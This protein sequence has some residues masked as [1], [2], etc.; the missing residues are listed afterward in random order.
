M[1]TVMNLA[2]LI[3]ANY[4][5]MKADPELGKGAVALEESSNACLELT[6]FFYQGRQSVRQGPAGRC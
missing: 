4:A 1:G 3:R 6:M 5:K 2:G